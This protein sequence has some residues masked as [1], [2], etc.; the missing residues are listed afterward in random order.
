MG[1]RR[2][3]RVGPSRIPRTGG[4]PRRRR[5]RGS[6]RARSGSPGQMHGLVVLDGENR[7][8]PAGDP[9]ERRPHRGRVRRDRAPGRARPAGRADRE[10]RARRV[11][12]PEA[13]LAAPSRARELCAHPPRAAPEGLHP[14]EADRR[15][16]DRRLGCVRHAALRRRQAQR[17]RPRCVAAL[18]IPAEWL[19]RGARV[20]RGRREPGIRRPLRSASGS[21]G[22]GSCRW[23]SGRPGSSSPCCPATAP[24]RAGAGAHVL[25][26]RSRTPGTRWG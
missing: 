20:D 13:P 3:S 24:E 23:R 19:P 14:P 17:G 21:T 16:R 2:R 5:S 22:R 1:S 8:D 26:R 7:C 25:P 12:G 11:H 4:A 15:A 18:E 10:P 6:R 9:L